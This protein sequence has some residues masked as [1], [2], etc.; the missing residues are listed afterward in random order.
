MT[1]EEFQRMQDDF[2]LQCKAEEADTVTEG[3]AFRKP[4]FSL[5]ASTM[6]MQ[7]MIALGRMDS[8][9]GQPVQKNLEQARF[10]IQSLM[11]LQAKSKANASK[12]ESDFLRDSLY[13][14][15]KFYMEETENVV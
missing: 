9:T 6:S 5:M 15:Q 11:V 12:E 7:A 8:P 3:K 13:H 2:E 4:S 1:T 10:M 14:L